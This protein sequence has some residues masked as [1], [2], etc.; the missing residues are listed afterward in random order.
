MSSGT[1][2]QVTGVAAAEIAEPGDDD[3][4]LDVVD[5]RITSV[6]RVDDELWVRGLGG[7]GRWV[8]GG[9]MVDVPTVTELSLRARYPHASEDAMSARYLLLC[10]W[11]DDAT[12]LRICSAP[13]RASTFT[14]PDGTWMPLP[15]GRR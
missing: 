3:L 13:G 9:A 4:D 1:L 12:P 2:R 15:R 10:R 8:D 14:A 6:V 7:F 11:R 5:V